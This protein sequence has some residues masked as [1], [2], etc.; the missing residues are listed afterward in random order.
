MAEA[1]PKTKARVEYHDLNLSVLAIAN[2]VRSIKSDV[3]VEKPKKPNTDRH[4][5]YLVELK[6]ESRIIVGELTI[7][8]FIAA[9]KNFDNRL[10]GIKVAY[11]FYHQGVASS[12]NFDDLVCT[13]NR[14]LRPAAP[15]ATDK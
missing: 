14:R 8:D 2:L 11:P 12:I 7:M 10:R 3:K 15:L 5:L 4:E 1:I 13:L 9:Q 6:V